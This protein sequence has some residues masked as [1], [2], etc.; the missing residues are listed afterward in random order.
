MKYIKWFIIS[1]FL[2]LFLGICNVVN[3]LEMNSQALSSSSVSGYDIVGYGTF[4]K[5]NLNFRN[6]FDVVYTFNDSNTI[7]GYDY[8]QFPFIMQYNFNGTYTETTEINQIY[9]ICAQWENEY[10]TYQ[11]GS[12]ATVSQC[13]K[14][15]K[16]KYIGNNTY[17][18]VTDETT[19]GTE[20]NIPYI[21]LSIDIFYN[22]GK[23]SPCEVNTINY[24]ST[25]FKCKV[26]SDST[27]ITRIRFRN[28]ASSYLSSNI[29][30]QLGIGN[31]YIMWKDP[32]NSM[33]QKQD[34]T[35]NQLQDMNDNMTSTD[36]TGASQDQNN[37]INNSAFQDNTGL[38]GII[39]APL[40]M[41]SSLTN[42]CQPIQFTL[43]YLK[44][45]NL[46]I[47]CMGNFLQNKIP[48]LVII[49]KVIVN[50]FICY[51]IGLDL[52]KIV[53]NARDPDNDRIEV[54]DL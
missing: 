24:G 54:L 42:H 17:T 44:D 51:L 36:I 19:T 21:S 32:I 31:Y 7:T 8:I 16:V 10:I 45:T 37:F 27:S 50:G 4:L 15:M 25:Y 12:T 11:D 30:G 18:P 47:P 40:T 22:N 5:Q 41:I 49:V 14:W 20:T 33:T 1:S 29:M 34:E 53:K 35:N 13:A 3:A 2:I 43:P 28:Q 39:T 48:S 52:F 9:M 26:P 46:T 23:I 38:S 6:N